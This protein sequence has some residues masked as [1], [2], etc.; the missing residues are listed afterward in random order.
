MGM[1]FRFRSVSV[2]FPFRFRSVSVPFP[3]RFRSVSVPFPFRSVSVPFPFRFRS[4]S[5]PF[6]FRFRSVS[7]PFPFRFRSVSVPFPFRSITDSALFPFN[8]YATQ[9][10][11]T[12]LLMLPYC[13]PGPFRSYR[14][15]LIYL[16]ARSLSFLSRS[17]SFTFHSFRSILSRPVSSLPRSVSHN[18]P[19]PTKMNRDLFKC[20]SS[21]S[22]RLSHAHHYFQ[23]TD[24]CLSLFQSLLQQHQLSLLGWFYDVI[25]RVKHAGYGC[26]CLVCLC[27]AC[28]CVWH[29][30]Q[31]TAPSGISGIL[32]ARR[33]AM[34][35]LAPSCCEHALG[36]FLC[37]NDVLLNT[38]ISV[39]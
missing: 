14:S 19:V 9:F 1:H 11:T 36:S 28:L 29:W 34:L 8:L 22:T 26:V 3:F 25:P 21:Y 30:Y 24:S 5:V 12:L 18:L 37:R 20:S 7:V 4:V 15:C 33:D 27:L 38:R 6:P 10:R 17:R 23:T 32:G 35:I 16:I 31:H 13:I 2:P 39:C